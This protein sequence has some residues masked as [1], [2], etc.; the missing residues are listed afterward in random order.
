MRKPLGRKAY[1]S[2][3][4]LPGSRLGSGDHHIEYGQARIATEKLRDKHDQLF[5]TEKLDGSNVSVAKL[6]DGRIVALTRSGYLAE[7]SPY[8]QHHIFSDWVYANLDRFNALLNPGEWVVGEWLAMAHGTRYVLQ[9]EPF[10]PFDLFSEGKRI[11]QS[12]FLKRIF[13]CNFIPPRV[14][15]ITFC[16]P[17][18]LRVA[19][20]IEDAIH[21]MDDGLSPHG[22]I[23]PIEGAVW[24]VE[25]E[26]RV[27]FLCKW[28]RPSKV[29]G[30]YLDQIRW[31]E[32]LEEYLPGKAIRKIREAQPCKI[33]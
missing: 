16:P 13:E 32:N 30:C 19:F 21:R 15:C 20:S 28:V 3:P 1:G 18:P 2:I 27:D 8:L 10:V 6:E 25:R 26:G 29:D 5:V 9:H 23:D 14:L 17:N 24:R 22:A 12:Q 33:E 4:H 31:N 7:T 11:L